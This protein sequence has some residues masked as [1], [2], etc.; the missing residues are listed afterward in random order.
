MTPGT[1]PLKSVPTADAAIRVEHPGSDSEVYG[2]LGTTASY[3]GAGLAA[4]FA[5]RGLPAGTSVL[6]VRG[7][8]APPDV[9]VELERL[10]AAVDVLTELLHRKLPLFNKKE[11]LPILE[12]AASGLAATGSPLALRLLR[13]EAGNPRSARGAA[14][15]Q[16]LNQTRDPHGR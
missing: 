7:D 11:A 13:K 9:E 12:A 10:G 15:A 5:D 1:W 4:A 16:A 8:L 3:E 2:V 6:R 14:C